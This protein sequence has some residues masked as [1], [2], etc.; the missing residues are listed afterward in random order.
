MAAWIAVGAAS[1]GLNKGSLGE[2]PVAGGGGGG[3]GGAVVHLRWALQNTMS[4]SPAHRS[5]TAE[6]S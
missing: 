3:G 1:S 5:A 4:K 6:N 2:A